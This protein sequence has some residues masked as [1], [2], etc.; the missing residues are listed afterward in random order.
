VES[1]MDQVLELFFEEGRVEVTG[2]VKE[3]L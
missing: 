1:T 3:I 2:Q